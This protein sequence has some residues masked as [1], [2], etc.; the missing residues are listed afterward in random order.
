VDE[1]AALGLRESV[2]KHLQIWHRQGLIDLHKS[3]IMIREVEAIKRL[4]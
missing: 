3:S 2:N 1:E 4:I